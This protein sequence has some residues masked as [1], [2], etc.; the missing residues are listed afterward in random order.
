MHFCFAFDSVASPRR[1]QIEAGKLELADSEFDLISLV[2]EAVDSVAGRAMASGLEV[3]CYVDPAVPTLLVGDPA[4]LRQV[5]LNLLSN[6]I[7]FTASGEV[8]LT[9]FPRA[10]ADAAGGP[11]WEYEAAWAC[12][13]ASAA[14]GSRKGLVAGSGDAKR[15][16]GGVGG[17]S[18]LF[19]VRDTGIG[20]SAEGRRKLF[21]RFSQARQKKLWVH[22]VLYFYIYIYIYI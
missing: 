7:K 6:A 2:E 10:V 22:G 8:C 3:C 5:L 12:D 18:L 1:F 14:S 11:S 9:V 21:S 15:E 16:E 17:V 19:A 4:R 13:E 20:I